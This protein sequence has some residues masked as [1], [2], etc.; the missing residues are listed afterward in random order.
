MVINQLRI[1]SGDWG[2]VNGTHLQGYIYRTTREE[3]EK[4]FGSPEEFGEGD[5]VTTEWAFTI[6]GEVGTIYDWKRYEMGVPLMEERI[7]WNVGGH[8]ADILELVLNAI[9]NSGVGIEER[10]NA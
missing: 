6:D 4:V 5:K 9:K 10:L 1:N 7:D 3:L 8:K 2:L